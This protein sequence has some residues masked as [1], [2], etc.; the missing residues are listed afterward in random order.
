[1]KQCGATSISDGIFSVGISERGEMRSENDDLP[2][3][4]KAAW[5]RCT[6]NDD[7]QGS[8]TKCLL[9]VGDDDED[10]DDDADDVSDGKADNLQ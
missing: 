8:S 10:E 4:W 1:M 5:G 6:Q 3:S 9:F 2:L 7:L